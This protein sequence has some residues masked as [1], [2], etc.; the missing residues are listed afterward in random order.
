V[1]LTGR[2]S[3]CVRD[4]LENPPAAPAR[5]VRAAKSGFTIE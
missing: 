2:D 4:L 3:L 1:Q 5:L